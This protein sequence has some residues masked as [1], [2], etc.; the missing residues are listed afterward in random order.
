MIVEKNQ[1]TW[2]FKPFE[3][4]R[5]LHIKFNSYLDSTRRGYQSNGVKP[6]ELVRGKPW[7]CEKTQQIP[8]KEDPRKVSQQKFYKSINGVY[9]WY[10]SGI[11]FANW[12]IIYHLPSIKGTTNSNWINLR[13]VFLPL[14]I[15]VE[16]KNRKRKVASLQ[17]GNFTWLINLPPA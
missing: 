16:K 4:E 3:N 9:K 5:F 10:R 7:R 8:F 15:Q 2:L 14:I 6:P 13:I 11:C 1:S 12:V 17:N